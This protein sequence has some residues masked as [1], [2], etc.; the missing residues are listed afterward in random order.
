LTAIQKYRT[1]LSRLA[2]PRS[3]WIAFKFW[4]AI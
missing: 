1:A 2:R 3:D 4:Y